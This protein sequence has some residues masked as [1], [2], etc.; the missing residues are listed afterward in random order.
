[1]GKP[2]D[3]TA[4]HRAVPAPEPRRPEGVSS[5]V[6]VDLAGLSHKGRVRPNNED[7]YFIARFERSMRTIATN[8]S[9]GDV[10]PR[11]SETAYG[12][13]VADGIGGHAAG[14]VASRT[15]I[16]ELVALALE[17]PDWIM[18]LDEPLAS[19]V[20]KRMEG[21]FQKVHDVLV[22]RAKADPTLRGMGTTLTLACSVG[23]DFVTA[24]VGDSRAYLFH[25][26]TLKRLTRDQTLAQSLAD[27]GE[28]RQDEVAAHPTRHILTGAIA[29]RGAFVQVELSHDRLADDDQLLLCTDGLT[30]MVS[31]GAIAEALSAAK[32]SAD[33]C[34]RLVDLAL[35]AGGKDNVTVA[36]GRYRIPDA[37]G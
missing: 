32:S 3:S 17:T 18:R 29:T 6:E 16:A 2:D 11:S 10:P 36:L 26:G 1:M 15:A 22:D 4:M 31:E 28:I 37:A 23:A 33:A 34:R 27:A 9:A 5:L 20:S 8:L 13:L 12:L 14:E 24:H 35:E 25:D 21:R 30:E 19:Q 7:H